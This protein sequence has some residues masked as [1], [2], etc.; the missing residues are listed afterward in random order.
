M[1]NGIHMVRHVGEGH[2]GRL[3]LPHRE[4]ATGDWTLHEESVT[5]QPWCLRD[6]PL[7]PSIGQVHRNK[8]P[9]MLETETG[10]NADHLITSQ[11]RDF[12][13]VPMLVGKRK[14]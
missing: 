12:M 5:D 1:A 4:S 8:H 3:G 6:I 11:R 7:Q 9:E 13:L 10:S 2:Q 14:Q